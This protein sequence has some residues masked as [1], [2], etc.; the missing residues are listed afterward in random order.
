MLDGFIVTLPAGDDSL[1][2]RAWWIYYSLTCWR[3][4]FEGGCGACLRCRGTDTARQRR[5][6]FCSHPDPDGVRP[7]CEPDWTPSKV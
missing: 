7:R 5:L 6:A 2:F 1:G 4:Q 3:E